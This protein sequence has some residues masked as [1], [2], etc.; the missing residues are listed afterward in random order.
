MPNR[1]LGSPEGRFE[2]S[3]TG[4]R[5]CLCD[6]SSYQSL[7]AIYRKAATHKCREIENMFQVA[8]WKESA[9]DA[10]G[11]AL[12]GGS[13]LEPHNVRRSSRIE[14]LVH[15]AIEEG[16][17]YRNHEQESPARISRNEDRIKEKPEPCHITSKIP[18]G[19]SRAQS[20]D[21]PRYRS[22]TTK[23]QSECQSQS[24]AP[25]PDVGALR[26]FDSA[27]PAI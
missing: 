26:G 1:G 6:A 16:P 17:E 22:R 25:T 12:A 3:G 9:T 18:P 27:I 2:K 21:Q 14:S 5:L 4:S 8:L 23:M 19:P 13:D 11:A 15:E 20:F 24:T 7:S 10:T